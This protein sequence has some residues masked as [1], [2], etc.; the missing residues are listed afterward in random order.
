MTLLIAGGAALPCSMITRADQ[1]LKPKFIE[2]IDELAREVALRDIIAI[3]E[4]YLVAKVLLIVHQLVGDIIKLGIEL[5]A[6]AR[7]GLM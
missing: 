6:F 2:V 7:L 1:A 5:I 4:H 3:A